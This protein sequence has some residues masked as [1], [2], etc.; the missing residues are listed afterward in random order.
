MDLHVRYEGDDDPEKCTAKKLERFG[1]ATLHEHNSA[2]PW[3]LVLSPFAK[4]ALSPA[5]RDVTETLVAMDLSWETAEKARFELSGEHRALPFLLA[6]NPVN[7]GRPYRLTTVEAF[8]GALIILGERTQAETILSKFRW[9]QTFLDLNE[10]PLERYANCTDSSEV[11]E[12]QS[13]Y[14]EMTEE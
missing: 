12:V 13:E 4:Q 8:A 2:T 14:L 11:V 1:L 9:G 10:E 7:Y 3:G 5:D 6:G